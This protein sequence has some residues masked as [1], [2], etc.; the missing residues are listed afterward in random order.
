MPKSSDHLNSPHP[1]KMIVSSKKV[2]VSHTPKLLQLLGNVG[3]LSTGVA[4]LVVGEPR[5]A[6]AQHKGRQ[7][8]EKKRD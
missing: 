6:A 5:N 8:G 7:I 1:T 3:D 2:R 4:N